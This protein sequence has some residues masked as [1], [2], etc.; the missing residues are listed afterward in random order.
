MSA[1]KAAPAIGLHPYQQRWFNDRHRFKIGMFARQTGKTFVTTLEIVDD[2]FEKMVDGRR[3][4]WVILSSGERQ[5]REAMESGIKPHAAAYGLALR[6]LG[7]SGTRGTPPKVDARALEV[8]FPNGARVTALPANPDTARGFSANVYLDEFA[9]HRDDR[10]I[11]RALF[12]VISAGH[13][14][15]VTSTP[16]GK[17]NKFHELMSA[18]DDDWSRHVVDIHQAVADGLPR[19]IEVLRRNVGDADAW[20]QEYELKFRERASAW[21][22]HGLVVANE[23]PDAGKLDLYQGGPCYIGNDIALRGDL[24]VAW[25]WEEVGDVLWTREIVTLRQATF[26][27]Q[28]AAL[29]ALFGRYRVARLQMDQT[30]LGE[31]PVEDAKRRYGE[32]KVQ[33]VIFTTGN[34]LLLATAG[35]QAF[36][37]RRARIPAGDPELR[38]D[39]MKLRK[40]AGPT[41]RPRF[42]AA[43]NAAG[44]ADRAWAAFLGIEAAAGPPA[45]AGATVEGG[46][47]SYAAGRT[48]E[49]PT[50]WR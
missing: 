22:P 43:S 32:A 33:G 34:K 47:N 35:K 20:A 30:G 11:W 1:R 44:H 19:D 31:K 36:E 3:A 5:A 2:I 26:A 4:H 28:D 29:D 13:S 24:W 15:R 39:F 50:S 23:H 18:R 37:A 38:A 46:R 8:V 27:Q 10:R 12:P 25:V 45:A 48:R 17:T 49:K 9:F 40:V 21:L 14:L 6:E 41:G 7:G 42:I 16:N